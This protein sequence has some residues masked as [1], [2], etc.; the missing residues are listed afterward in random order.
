GGGGGGGG[1][2][3][4][5]LKILDMGCGPGNM[6]DYLKTLGDVTGTDL[7][8]SALSYCRTRGYDKLFIG[9]GDSLPVRDNEFDLVVALDVIEHIEDD[10]G[11]LEEIYRVIR[12]GGRVCLTVPAYMFLWGDHDE[13]YGH[14]RRYTATALAGKLQRAGFAID[15]VSYFEAPF[16]VPLFIFRSIKR[17]AGRKGKPSDDFISIPGWMNRVLMGFLLAEGFFFR[18]IRIPFGVTIFCMASKPDGA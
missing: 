11:A 6:L 13:I 2:G 3:G 4:A 18:W 10:E 17:L 15:R 14:K 8:V 9:L 7:S 5:G 16:V 1:G 12:P